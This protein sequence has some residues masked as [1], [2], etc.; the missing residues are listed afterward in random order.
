MAFFKIPENQFCFSMFQYNMKTL[1]E[2]IC[3]GR[4]L[5]VDEALQL[6]DADLLDLGKAAEI[7]RER[8]HQGN[9][10]TFII[11]RNITFTNQCIA[12]CRFCA[13]YAW[14]K[15]DAYLLSIEEIVDRI[16]EL[17]QMGGTQV[18]LQGGLNPALSLQ[19]YC[20]LLSEIK[21]HFS[22]IW[23]HSFSPAEIS[24][25]SKNSGLSIKNVLIK[26]KVAGLDSLPGA[27]EILVDRVRKLVSPHKLTTS[28]W[29]EVM[30]EAHKIGMHTTATMTFG[31]METRNERIEHLLKIRTLQDKTKGFKAFIP[32]SFSPRHT[33]LSKLKMAGGIEYL[34]TVAIS[35]IFLDNIENIHA[36]WVTEGENLAQIALFFGAND[37]GGILMEEEVI[38]S[39]GIEYRISLQKMIELIQFAGKIPAQR[40]SKYEIIH[41]YKNSTEIMDYTDD[42]K[43][44]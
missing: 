6:Y 43:N 13:F 4:R 34:K 18:M 41:E 15:D 10:V 31:L 36:G 7:C 21:S 38:K 27:A 17:V 14:K 29:L 9:R 19:Y 8:I 11:D 32:W 20:H 1:L 25:L 23:L 26:L 24:F 3:S 35:R 37:M 12:K 16:R 33:K 30:E 28:E 44:R 39:T 22:H 2:K 5:V 42:L 40:N